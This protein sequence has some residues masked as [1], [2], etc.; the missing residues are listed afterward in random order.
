MAPLG[1]QIRSWRRAR[2]VTQ[3]AVAT[4]AGT[5]TRHL[6]FIENGRSWPGHD[7]VER[8]SATLQVPDE[9][10]HLLLAHVARGHEV[11]NVAVPVDRLAPDATDLSELIAA[12]DPFPACV[13][14]A[15]GV[16]RHAN[17]TYRRLAPGI[18][19]MSPEEQVDRFFGA[20]GQ[21]WVANWTEIAL[22]EANRRIC[23]SQSTAS[24]EGLR[25]G[26]RA[27]RHVGENVSNPPSDDRRPLVHLRVG[28]GEVIVLKTLTLVPNP[29]SVSR[30][31][32]VE[33][34]LPADAPSRRWFERMSAR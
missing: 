6:S 17:S 12:Y 10:R 13:V 11:G 20:E 32:V 27:L 24:A 3:L 28:E 31:A 9:A 7:L 33:I 8:L 21:R 4:A 5:T 23:T 26:L 22:R 25:L 14:D 29:H 30:D 1:A 34:A 19:E 16:V 18:L 15:V 2:G